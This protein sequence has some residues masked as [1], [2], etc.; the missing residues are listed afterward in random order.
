VSSNKAKE[1]RKIEQCENKMGAVQLPR[2]ETNRRE[3][4]G[5]NA[6][7]VSSYAAKRTQKKE[8]AMGPRGRGYR[9]YVSS[10]SMVC[11]GAW[12]LR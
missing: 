11:M 2:K 1:M 7:G 8:D 10:W 6:M 9:L 4:R 5:E 3:T 12:R